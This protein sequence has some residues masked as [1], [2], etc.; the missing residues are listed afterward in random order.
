MIEE[1]LQKIGVSNNRMPLYDQ[2]VNQILQDDSL[3]KKEEVQDSLDSFIQM[4]GQINKI[5]KDNEPQVEPDKHPNLIDFLDKHE[6]TKERINLFIQN[7]HIEDNKYLAAMSNF[8]N[9]K[10][11]I[12][13][14]IYE[15]TKLDN[16]EEKQK[17]QDLLNSIIQLDNSIKDGKLLLE[18]NE[19]V[20]KSIRNNPEDSAT[21]ISKFQTP[22]TLK[23]ILKDSSVVN[24][25]FIKKVSTLHNNPQI[26]DQLLKFMS[27]NFNVFS[28]IDDG[29]KVDIFK[30]HVKDS[31]DDNFVLNSVINSFLVN[32]NQPYETILEDL[33]NSNENNG[34][35]DVSGVKIKSLKGRELLTAL[36]YTTN[37]DKLFDNL[38]EIEGIFKHGNKQEAMVAQ[39]AFTHYYHNT[40]E[41]ERRFI[42]DHADSFSSMY[43]PTHTSTIVDLKDDSSLKAS[44]TIKFSN[45]NTDKS[46]IANA[47]NYVIPEKHKDFI[48]KNIGNFIF[49]GKEST[50]SYNNSNINKA[51]EFAKQYG[52]S[53][54]KKHLEEFG[55]SHF[56]QNDL[57][58]MNDLKNINK[59]MS[60][61]SLDVHH[62]SDGEENKLI[63]KANKLNLFKLQRLGTQYKD[64]MD[65]ID[66]N[67]GEADYI[68]KSGVDVKRIK[69]NIDI[70][71]INDYNSINKDK[72]PIDFLQMHNI[73]FEGHKPDQVLK[74]HVINYISNSNQKGKLYLPE[75]KIMEVEDVIPHKD[76]EIVQKSSNWMETINN[77]INYKI[78]QIKDRLF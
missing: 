33:F 51:I 68:V 71:M 18:F 72:D 78:K 74:E 47:L 16:I 2:L 29:K 58:S 39:K 77:S 76:E 23:N 10:R 63:F 45:D 44:R 24:D 48:D 28:N 6:K 37:T 17:R 7:P 30:E 8:D 22:E 46:D 1:L 69:P 14:S 25:K 15:L 11:T 66:N 40:D 54:D 36:P 41:K 31:I 73:L 4:N 26:Q 5:I 12:H 64:F 55:I 34:L 43:N 13:H 19:F 42:S 59:S 62:S 75:D 38:H 53:V 20:K 3:L 9:K 21:A 32:I 70:S 67:V 35:I 27:G 61:N 56:L 60:K 57:V 65:S 49:G 50:V 52:G